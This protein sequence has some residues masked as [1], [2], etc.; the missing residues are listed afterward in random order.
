[1]FKTS[2]LYC[3]KNAPMRDHCPSALYSHIES[4]TEPECL[5][6]RSL[7]LTVSRHKTPRNSAFIF[8]VTQSGSSLICSLPI[9]YNFLRQFLLSLTKNRRSMGLNVL[10]FFE[11]HGTPR[12][13]VQ[14]IF[15]LYRKKRIYLKARH[16]GHLTRKQI[17]C[18]EI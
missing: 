8:W 18:D 15:I 6:D 12:L 17:K 9:R 13:P 14:V 11:I 4:W 10:V 1:M 3:S 2:W 5:P 7:N 16:L